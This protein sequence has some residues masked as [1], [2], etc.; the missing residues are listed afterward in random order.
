[1]QC[2][3]NWCTPAAFAQLS[4]VTRLALEGH[5]TLGDADFSALPLLRELSLAGARLTALPT[6]V[7]G[8]QHLSVLD[9][10][11]NRLTGLP[12]GRYLRRLR[13]L[14]LAGNPI[15]ALPPALEAA[16]ALEALDVTRCDPL[17][18]GGM[19]AKAS[20]GSAVPLAA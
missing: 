15:Q 11:D 17:V 18:E 4:R 10:T 7:T 5:N 8:L 6:G 12:P 19:L 3:H 1:M 13:E 9:L 2:E 16:T 20:Q 14:S